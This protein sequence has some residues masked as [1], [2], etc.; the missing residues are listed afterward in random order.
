M[1]YPDMPMPTVTYDFPQM[2]WQLLVVVEKLIDN[3]HS[4]AAAD[5]VNLATISP[6]CSPPPPPR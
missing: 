5:V 2:L 4:K 3:G 1:M 6:P